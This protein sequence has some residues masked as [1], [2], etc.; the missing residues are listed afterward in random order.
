LN[1]FIFSI[2]FK[3]ILVEL[4]VL[5]GVRSLFP[6]FFQLFLSFL[7]NL[8]RCVIQSLLK[9]ILSLCCSF[10]SPTLVKLIPS[11]RHPEKCNSIKN[12]V[13]DKAHDLDGVFL[14]KYSIYD[15]FKDSQKQEYEI[16]DNSDLFKGVVNG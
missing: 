1:Q 12:R 8:K 2:V 14:G 16:A 3:K 4:L 7:I 9:I 15:L 13:Y 11:L 6:F 10:D 5:G